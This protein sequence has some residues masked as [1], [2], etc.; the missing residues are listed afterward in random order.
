MEYRLYKLCFPCGVHFG[1]NSL[2]STEF[3]FCAD[4]L[5]SALYIEALKTSAE[6]AEKFYHIAEDE[7]FFL[8][9]AMP[10]CENEYYLP[11]PM[12]YV[13]Y[14]QEIPD[15]KEI[16]ALKK[17]KYIPISKFSAYMQGSY[18]GETG[19]IN[20]L[21]KKEV[22][23][24]AHIRGQEETLP[25]RVGVYYFNQ[26]N[27]LY[28]IV[29]AKD[30]TSLD[31]IEGLIYQLSYSGIGGK[32]SAGQGRFIVKEEELPLELRNRIHASGDT[33]M[34]LSVSLPKEEELEDIVSTSK[35]YSLQKRS[36][37]V[38]SDC[39]ADEYLRKKDLYVF[40]AGS[41]FTKRYK[42]DIVDVSSHGRHPV[43]RYAKPLFMGVDV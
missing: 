14:K 39:Y 5:F 29:G 21:G 31:F 42:G 3:L 26:G 36:G 22:K 38:Y 43:Y 32:R 6:L 34:T 8:S 11:R 25:F 23:V 19:G 12:M 15:A 16:K 41:C 10:F 37:F 2:E 17:I 40:A 33:Y 24:S 35:G 4:T 18:K 7:E 27:G 13:E 28:I 9:D 20:E 1:V 30:G